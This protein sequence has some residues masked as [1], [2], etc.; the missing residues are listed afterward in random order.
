MPEVSYLRLAGPEG[1]LAG[2]RSANVTPVLAT[3][4]HTALKLPPSFPPASID[5][6]LLPPAVPD[7]PAARRQLLAPSRALTQASHNTSRP[8]AA[9]SVWR[10]P[11]STSL[12]NASTLV[13]R[14]SLSPRT[15]DLPDAAVLHKRLAAQDTAS[16]LLFLLVIGGLVDTTAASQVR[17]DI[18]NSSAT[19]AAN[20]ATT[21]AGACCTRAAVVCVRPAPGAL[22]CTHTWGCDT[23]V[24]QGH[25]HACRCRHH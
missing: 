4:L 10:D 15:P 18:S 24:E 13:W 7:A 23:C 22:A 20:N 25:A 16:N 19:A 1:A 14:F 6:Q 8:A 11:R 5:L 21:S 17:A 12:L 9:A 3:A 2:L